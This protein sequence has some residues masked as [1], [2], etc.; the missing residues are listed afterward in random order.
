MCVYAKRA[1]S[2]FYVCCKEQQQQQHTHIHNELN[3]QKTCTVQTISRR[4]TDGH[5][6]CIICTLHRTCRITVSVVF[7]CCVVVFL[8]C[9][10]LNQPRMFVYTQTNLI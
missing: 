8:M 2:E 9:I 1:T 4:P 5:T 7:C 10:K 6:L 3:C